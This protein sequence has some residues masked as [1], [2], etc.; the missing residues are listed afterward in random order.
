MSERIGSPDVPAMS[1]EHSSRSCASRRRR[2]TRAAPAGARLGRRGQATRGAASSRA[3]AL[4]TACSRSSRLSTPAR[5]PIL[6]HLATENICERR[7]TQIAGPIRTTSGAT[8][9]RHRADEV[10]P[11]KTDA[12]S[13]RRRRSPGE[14]D[15]K[16][17]RPTR[18]REPERYCFPVRRALRIVSAEAQAV[19]LPVIAHS[20]SG[21]ATRSRM[22]PAL[23][24][25][26]SP[27]DAARRAARDKRSRDN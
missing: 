18:R 25:G 21:P 12:E 10:A 4:P 14:L 6:G 20:Y 11:V 7:R 22:G 19:G 23:G 8:F 3:C 17:S 2:G 16:S 15:D 13:G 27:P 26:W 5:S 9:G 1:G 24:L